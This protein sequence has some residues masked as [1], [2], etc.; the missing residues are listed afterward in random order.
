[1]KKFIK[2]F[3]H[4]IDGLWLELKRETNLKIDIIIMII[5]I[6]AGIILK[7]TK[8]EWI[9]CIIL[10]SIVISGELFNTSIE[11][12]VD[13]IMPE[14]NDKAKAIKDISAGAVLILAI[15]SAIIG[16]LIFI[17]KII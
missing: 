11:R 14:K 9:I 16:G 6:V 1:M 2:S 17:P 5:I 13:V 7:I 15:G 3:K 4:A 8:I 10:F 12:I